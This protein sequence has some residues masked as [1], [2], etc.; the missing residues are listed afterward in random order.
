MDL[1]GFWDDDDSYDSFFD[2][3]DDESGCTDEDSA[4]D[5]Q[6]E[7]CNMERKDAYAAGAESLN[8]KAVKSA[9]ENY[10]DIF[11]LG[12]TSAK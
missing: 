4:P 7:D 2:D 5:T 12:K 11:A 6:S 10:R 3:K 8:T 9:Q 1:F